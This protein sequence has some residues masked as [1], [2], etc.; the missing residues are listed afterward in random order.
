[1]S[2]DHLEELCVMPFTL[3]TTRKPIMAGL[4]EVLARITGAG[5]S[6]TVWLNGSFLTER[7]D[8]GDVDLV[9]LYPPRFYDKGTDAQREVIDWLV[10]RDNLPKTQFHCDTHAEPIYPEGTPMHHMVEG[11]LAYWRQIYGHEIATGKPKGIA[12]VEVQGATT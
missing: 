5:I 7:I 12:V 10:G 2:L 1:M 8:P 3:S 9:V 6:C 4:R 11:A